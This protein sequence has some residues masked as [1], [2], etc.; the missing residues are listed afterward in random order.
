MCEKEKCGQAKCGQAKCGQEKCGSVKNPPGIICVTNR[1]LCIVPFMEQLRKVAEAGFLR[2]ILREKDLS[3]AAYR[4]LAEEFL[5][6]CRENGA[7]GTLHTHGEIAIELM[8]RSLHL[9]INDLRG[10]KRKHSSKR[11]EN[12]GASVHSVEEALEAQALGAD[13]VTAGHI[14]PTDCKKGIPGRGTDFLSQVVNAV[15]IPVYAIG[16]INSENLKMVRESGAAGACI[17]SS[18][19][20]AENPAFLVDEL[21]RIWDEFPID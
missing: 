3:L 21:Q 11:F 1:A 9:S 4:E 19:M 5:H 12:L 20:T 2:V 18:A 14:F 15:D 7:E 8:A 10:W 16:G 17:M 6:I 13:Y